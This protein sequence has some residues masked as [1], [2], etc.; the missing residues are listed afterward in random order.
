MEEVKKFHD[1]LANASLDPDNVKMEDV[2][3]L[4]KKV[5]EAYKNENWKNLGGHLAK[6]FAGKVPDSDESDS[7]SP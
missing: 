3:P 1:A 5:C 7:E 2:D 6:R 4:Y